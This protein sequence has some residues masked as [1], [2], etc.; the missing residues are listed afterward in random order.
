MVS[1]TD[2]K[3]IRVNGYSFLP[4]KF[5]LSSYHYLLS[6]PTSL[7]RAYGVTIFVTVAGTLSSLFFTALLAYPLSRK[8]FPYRD[9][10]AF[11]IFFTILFNG[12]LV[13]WY[14]VYTNLFDF[15]DS[16]LALIV[17]GLLLNG[18][19]V[20]I[21]RT[22]F[23]NTIPAAIIES[24]QID[25]AGE[26]RIFFQL[27]L[28]LSIPV[29][30][31]IGLFTTLGYWNEWF[32]SLVFISDAHLFS[33]QYLM[34]K[35]LLNINFLAENTQNSN[36]AKLLADMPTETVRMAMA[37]MGIGPIIFAYPFFQKYLV[38]GLTVGAIKG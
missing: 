37:I 36:S 15:R 13:P 33:L 31:T 8:D 11:Y 12:G 4:E 32:N 28:P 27:I 34:T 24:A 10:L 14:L 5:S 23:A 17:P 20:L 9:K 22:F 38:K 29:L 16:L 21:M 2:E 6:D 3:S 19:N 1:I 25:G 35:T 18:F 7:L 30:A 26:L